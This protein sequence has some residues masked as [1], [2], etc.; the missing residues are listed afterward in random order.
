MRIALVG[1]ECEENLAL[2]YIQA[3]LE[4][5]GHTVALIP[6]NS[7]RS[8]DAAAGELARSQAAV[9]G[10]S[11]VFTYRA[12]EFA[13]LARRSRELGYAGYIVAGG[14]FAALNAE[15]LLRDV[16][17][18]D[19]V[20]VGEGEG[21]LCALADRLG[22]PEGVAG[23][24]WRGPTGSAVRN[25]PAAAPLDIDRLARPTHLSPPDTYLGLPIANVLSSRGCTHAC[26]FCS[27]AAW[28]RHCGAPRFRLRRPECV[29][30]ELADLYRR[31]YRIFNFHDDNFVLQSPRDMSRRVDLLQ[32]ALRARGVGRIAFA[33]KSRPD[34]ID[35]DLFAQLKA[36][37]L[38][39]VFVGIEAGTATSLRQL[40]RRQTPDDNA[41]ALKV[42]NRLGLH[43]CFNLLLL[44]PDSTLADFLANVD[45]LR[46]HARNP[47]NY[48]R[49]EIYAGTPLEAELRR[50]GRLRGSYWGYDYRI[51]DPRAQA[52]FELMAAT[53]FERHHGDDNVHHLAMRLDYE[54]QLLGHFFHCPPELARRVRTFV[55]RVNLRSCDLLDALGRQA[56][57]GFA[58]PAE[59]QEFVAEFRRRVQALNAAD[60]EAGMRMLWHLRAAA[61]RSAAPDVLL[62]RSAV[63]AGLAAALLLGGAPAGGAAPDANDAAP[64]AQSA[65]EAGRPADLGDPHLIL[66]EF[67][68][69]LGRYLGRCIG[70]GKPV[71]VEL[72]VDDTGRVTRARFLKP[73]APHSDTALSDEQRQKAVALIAQLGAEKYETRERATEALK[74]MDQPVLP[75]VT[76]A[77]DAASDPEVQERCRSV[78]AA[79]NPEL[80]FAGR[81]EVLAHLKRLVFQADKAR[82]Q[83]F[84]F[85]YTA[86]APDTHMC[87][88]AA[89]PAPRD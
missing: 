6:F 81:A 50:T 53:L 61:Q 41:R 8:L 88:M 72:W 19:A 65:G 30:D 68:A 49:T 86:T 17:A 42:L 26:A 73:H 74:K 55:R 7:R 79:I 84:L 38:F 63:A 15:N 32:D 18:I 46:A 23:L 75:L 14:H 34:R 5:A 21:I 43:V 59:R 58:S 10:F 78:M 12:R 28:H 36:M 3:A 24:I 71:D 82:G 57:Q 62:P 89:E 51:R 4:Q 25:P 56:A 80:D 39:R 20:A 11:M 48:C 83:H 13:D 40:G 2:R 1:A 9:A 77:L 16:A 67:D 69:H 45:F 27:I 33:I 66:A 60:R 87:E 64:A 35:R 44:N 22:R 37:G 85:T 29:A 52:A 47:M 31:G 54:R 70:W 76:Q